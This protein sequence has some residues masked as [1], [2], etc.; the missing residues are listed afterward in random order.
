MSA[1]P[2]DVLAVLDR[3]AGRQLA[4]HEAW[5]TRA[6]V[7][8]LIEAGKRVT[9]AFRDLGASRSMSSD[10]LCRRE[11]EAAMVAFDAALARC[12]GQS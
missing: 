7:A 12:G 11:C 4:T 3:M 2:V 6:A 9:Q 5:A 8:E 10:L 1:Q